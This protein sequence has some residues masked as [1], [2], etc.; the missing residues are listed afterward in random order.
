VTR[1]GAKH[2]PAAKKREL[3]ERLA[4][5]AEEFKASQEAD[6]RL[7]PGNEFPDEMPP[8]ARRYWRAHMIWGAIKDRWIRHDP[9]LAPPELLGAWMADAMLNQ[10]QQALLMAAQQDMRDRAEAA[11]LVIP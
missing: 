1:A 4:A 5:A 6:E 2:G 9:W 3:Q 8:E 10:L 7:I 11:G